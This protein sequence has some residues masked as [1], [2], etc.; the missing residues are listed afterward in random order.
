MEAVQR[1]DVPFFNGP[2]WLLRPSEL[3]L[4]EHLRGLI[5]HITR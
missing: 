2:L 5:V 4:A 3:D 1:G